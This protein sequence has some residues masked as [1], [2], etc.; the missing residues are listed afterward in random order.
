[1]RFNPLERVVSLYN[2]NEFDISKGKE[3]KKLK[4]R[5]KRSNGA[6]CLKV[7]AW[8]IPKKDK[9]C[10]ARIAIAGRMKQSEYSRPII[11]T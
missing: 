5:G 2:W 7:L 4:T 11:V 3:A 10:N 6:T 1:M 8:K 9:A